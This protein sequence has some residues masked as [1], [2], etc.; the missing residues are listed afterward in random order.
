[1]APSRCSVKFYISGSPPKVLLTLR[2]L[3]V[4]GVGVGGQDGGIEC[5]TDKAFTLCTVQQ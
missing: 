5:E 4:G 3:E 2:L 1:M